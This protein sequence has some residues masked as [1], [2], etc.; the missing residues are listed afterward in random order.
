MAYKVL[1]IKCRPQTFDEV[2]GQKHVTQTLKNAIK[3]KRIAHAFLF[4]GERGV[5]KT[6]IARILAKALNCHE[7]PTE[8]PCNKCPSCIEITDG[9]SI[10]VHEIDGAS[11]TGVDA[12]RTLRENARYLPARDKHKIYI[13]D[14]VHM[15]STSAFNA[16]LKTL[17]EPPDHIIFMFATTEPQKIPDTIIS[18]CLRFD[19][20]RISSNEIINHLLNIT[21]RENISISSKGLS[22]IAREAD[23]SMR[24]SQTIL[25]RAISYCGINIEDSTLE[26][27]LGHIDSQFIYRIMGA[28]ISDN[29]QACMDTV[30]ESYEYGVDFKK[31]YYAIL[32]HIRDLIMV[33]TLKDPKNHLTILMKT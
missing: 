24:D 25:E 16:L 5:G 15:L 27:I 18:R 1:A 8:Q 10:D 30:N 22:L 6:S 7:G 14:E 20:K 12:I 17:E 23:G 4:I 2:I 33:K 28:V 19:L 29:S 3:E 13:I 11:H 32:E 9:N 26:E 21:K 31:F